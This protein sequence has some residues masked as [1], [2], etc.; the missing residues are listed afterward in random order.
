MYKGPAQYGASSYQEYL[1]SS[2]K[3]VTDEALIS[4]FTPA[5]VVKGMKYSYIVNIEQ[6]GSTSRAYDNTTIYA[7]GDIYGGISLAKNMYNALYSVDMPN[8][9]SIVSCR[10]YCGIQN[11]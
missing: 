1:S 5:R 8:Y 10:T 7:N 2:S 9:E 3:L 11:S 4:V 6:C